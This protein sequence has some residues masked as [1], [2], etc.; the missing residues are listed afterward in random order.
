[1]VQDE[2]ARTSSILIAILSADT[3]VTVPLNLAGVSILVMTSA[4][5]EDLAFTEPRQLKKRTRR[6][7]NADQERTCIE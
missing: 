1:M 7:E 4:A 6:R 3:E 5:L 2:S